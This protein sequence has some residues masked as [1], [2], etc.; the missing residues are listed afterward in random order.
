M[1]PFLFL[2]HIAS[3]L[4]RAYFPYD[5]MQEV[6][7]IEGPL[8]P[9]AWIEWVEKLYQRSDPTRGRFARC[10][11]TAESRRVVALAAATQVQICAEHDISITAL[12]EPAYPPLL[13]HIA[14][15]P[16]C[17]FSKG[18]LGVLQRPQIAVIGSRRC[19]QQAAYH[20]YSLGYKAAQCG[21]SIVSGGA[22][23]CDIAAHQGVLAA[24][25]VPL[26]AVAVFAGGFP[27]IGPQGNLRYFREIE[28][29]GGILLTERLW[30]TFPTKRDF[31]VR[32]RL[33]SGLAPVTVVVQAG[34]RSGTMVTAKM[35]LDQGRELIVFPYESGDPWAE[36]SQSLIEEGAES[37]DSAEALLRLLHQREAWGSV[38][39]GAGDA[40]LV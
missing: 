1:Q 8:S 25:G 24:G 6:E 18:D 32:N 20:A 9:T 30:G 16:L 10:F 2:A 19:S 11:S 35:A 23:G 12:C 7:S 4:S 13:R 34:L 36:G 39:K 38:P 22:Y 37:V 29:A 21:I 5:C 27:L 17:L 40:A 33:I 26:P 14:D 3:Q 15:P 31:P 28:S